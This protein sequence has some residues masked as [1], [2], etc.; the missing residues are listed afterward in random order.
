MSPADHVTLMILDWS[1]IGNRLVLTFRYKLS[2]NSCFSFIKYCSSLLHIGLQ[3]IPQKVGLLGANYGRFGHKP[4]DYAQT[5]HQRLC[6]LRL[7]IA[8]INHVHDLQWCCCNTAYSNLIIFTTS[9]KW[10]RTTGIMNIFGPTYVS[11]HLH[12]IAQ[13][14]ICGLCISRMQLWRHYSDRQCFQ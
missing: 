10:P 9:G 5:F 8:S 1:L 14:W 3:Q 7:L 12:F 11:F 4:T 2:W 13:I 6:N